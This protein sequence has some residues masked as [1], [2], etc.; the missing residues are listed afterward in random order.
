S[1]PVV[2][3]ANS[4]T[5]WANERSNDCSPRWLRD[6]SDDAF[7][8][9][10]DLSDGLIRVRKCAAR[11]GSF[12]PRRARQYLYADYESD[13]RR[14][15]EARSDVGRRCCEPRAFGWQCCGELLDP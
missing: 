9:D 11:C 13:E 5:R 14:A 15:R 3:F 8:G 12:Q 7:G 2:R 6:R 10:A 4:L 1:L